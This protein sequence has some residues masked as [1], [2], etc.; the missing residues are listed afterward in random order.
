[1]QVRI[2]KADVAYV[3]RICSV[4]LVITMLIALLLSF[5]YSV[6]KDVIAEND[7]QKLSD[8]LSELFPDIEAPSQTELGS[9]DYPDEVDAFYA[10]YRGEGGELVGYYASVSPK[11]FKD[12][13]GLLVGLDTSGNVLGISVV[14]CSETVGIGDR[15]KEDSFLSGFNG[16]SGSV[17]YKKG[18]TDADVGYIDGISGATYSSKAVIVGVDAALRAYAIAA[19]G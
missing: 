14:S 15:I 2:K 8:A 3:A 1:M 17:K 11:G 6:T 7:A 18:A 10:V 13:V 16:I 5:V 9:D 19:A 4:L 12:D